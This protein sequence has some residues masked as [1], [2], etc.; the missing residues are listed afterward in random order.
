MGTGVIE[1]MVKAAASTI[2]AVVFSLSFI[3]FVINETPEVWEIFFITIFIFLFYFILFLSH[4]YIN[5]RK[6][7]ERKRRKK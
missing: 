2:A 4:S 3:G 7:K 1:A 6:R 5:E